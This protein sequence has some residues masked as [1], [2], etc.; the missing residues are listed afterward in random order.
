MQPPSKLPVEIKKQKGLA[1][2]VITPA[3]DLKGTA[4][5]FTVT[6]RLPAVIP[7]QNRNN[8]PNL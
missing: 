1:Q 7:S 6:E 8:V 4:S 3:T 2:S 5:P